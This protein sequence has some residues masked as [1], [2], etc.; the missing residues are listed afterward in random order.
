MDFDFLRKL[1]RCGWVVGLWLCAG[2]VG[3]GAQDFS[4]VTDPI[5]AYLSANPE[6]PGAG[7]RSVQGGRVVHEQ[8]WGGYD[9]QT[10]V[11]IASATKWLS[12][13]AIMSLVD[14]GLL[15]LDVPVSQYLP[16]EF[17]AGDARGGMTVR[18]MFSHSAGA[19][20]MSIFTSAKRITL[21]QSVGL[22][23]EHTAWV[24]EPGEEFRYGNVSMQVAGRVAEVVSGKDWEALFVE[25]VAEPLGL[26]GTDYQGLG[27]T[28]N[29]RIAGSGQSSVS[30]YARV[31]EMLANEGDFRGTR[32]LSAQAVATMLADQT[33]GAALGYAPPAIGTFKGYGIGNWVE[34]RDAEDDRPLEFSSPGLFGTTPWINPEAG[35]YGVF[36]I[37]DALLNVDGLMDEVR[38]LSRRVTPAIPEPGVLGVWMLGAVLCGRRRGGVAAMLPAS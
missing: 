36:V 26:T 25:R 11:R 13:V 34:L 38:A 6:I 12:G 35:V 8:Y 14:E 19:P 31:L 37:D 15:D 32:V 18:Q 29:P 22:I 23:A 30:D 21:E 33:A 28:S 2:S 24:A 17:G 1:R 7:L 3:A 20:G 10:Q 27:A 16:D 4:T 5:T 9:A